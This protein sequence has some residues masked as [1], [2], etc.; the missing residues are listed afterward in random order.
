MSLTERIDL[1]DVAAT[2]RLAARL[3]GLARRGDIFA[4]KGALGSGKTELARAFI[5][6]L[7]HS[8]EEVPSPTFTLLQGYDSAAGPLFHFDLYRL[9]APEQALELGIDDAFAD[10][11]C[12]IEW[13]ER[14][15]SLLPRRHLS[16]E[17]AAGAA[18]TERVARITGEEAWRERWRQLTAK[19]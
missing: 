14:L 9:A 19:A 3:A 11:I 13:P 12:L 18:M 2:G 6:S 7:T 8:A 17:L 5:R 1:P 15:G 4:L 10:G 16:I